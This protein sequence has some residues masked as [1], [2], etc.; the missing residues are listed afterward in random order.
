MI[1]PGKKIGMLGGGQLG[2]MSILA[3]RAM[4]Y[5]FAVFDPNPNCAAAMVAGRVVAT[6]CEDLEALRQFAAETDRVTLASDNIPA[7]TGDNIN[8]E[9]TVY[10]GRNVLHI[11]QHRRREKEFLRA[12]TIPCASVVV[13]HD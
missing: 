11:C 12:N 13:V 1:S 10:A 8:A 4:G 7:E 5:K 2:R 6:A 3:G 9:T